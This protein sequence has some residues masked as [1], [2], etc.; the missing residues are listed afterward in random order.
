MM[1]EMAEKK[2]TLGYAASEETQTPN[3]EGSA[4]YYRELP[5]EG[6]LLWLA[7]T[8][9]AFAVAAAVFIYSRLR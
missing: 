6:S 7:V 2:P 3:R 8:I 5:T 1:R 9:A 4:R